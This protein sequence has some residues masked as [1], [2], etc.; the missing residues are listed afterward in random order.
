MTICLI[1]VCVCKVL[2]G[3]ITDFVPWTETEL[4]LLLD[5][6]HSCQRRATLREWV[7]WA[8]RAAE[9]HGRWL[10]VLREFSSPENMATLCK[11]SEGMTTL[12]ES[13]HLCVQGLSTLYGTS[14]TAGDVLRMFNQS[15]NI[16]HTRSTVKRPQKHPDSD[17]RDWYP[18]ELYWLLIYCTHKSHKF[19][20]LEFP[21]PKDLSVVTCESLCSE[22]HNNGHVDPKNRLTAQDVAAKLE[23][24][25][26]SGMKLRT[27]ALSKY[28]E[29]AFTMQ[30]KT[31][32]G[33]SRE[34]WDVKPVLV[35][36]DRHQCVHFISPAGE[37]FHSFEEANIKSKLD[38]TR[39]GYIY[40][41]TLA[42]CV[43]TCGCDGRKRK[44]T[45]ELPRCSAQACREQRREAQ[46]RLIQCSSTQCQRFFHARCMDIVKKNISDGTP[47]YCQEHESEHDYS[48]EK[49][50][51]HS[52]H[53][54]QKRFECKW[55]YFGPS[56]NTHEPTES[57]IDLSVYK[58][59]VE[60][61]F[62]AED[63]ANLF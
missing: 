26:N 12:C 11:T 54:N 13:A 31:L 49:I 1:Y 6:L 38:D 59:Y 27:T 29:M 46:D 60:M 36:K 20:W 2:R 3:E 43:L 14:R 19:Q 8:A 30:L 5:Q 47:F 40:I 56:R 16:S 57:L 33:N 42:A 18:E 45:N 44:P 53:G 28:K 39:C 32:S 7:A 24:L 22:L 25:R 51:S 21:D 15:A 58:K 50:V 10:N 17:D 23:K 55:K 37:V 62:S 35:G 41:I 4:K 48:V 34:K 63:R 9:E 61:N 52:T